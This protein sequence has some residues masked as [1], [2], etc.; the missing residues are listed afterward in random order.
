[1]HAARVTHWHASKGAALLFDKVPA[2]EC[3]VC[4]YRLFDQATTNE[5]VRVARERPDPARLVTV[6]AYDLS[7]L[8]D[9]ASAPATAGAER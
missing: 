3:E 5:I 8:P 6:P 9:A 4:G 2:E 1:M 7:N